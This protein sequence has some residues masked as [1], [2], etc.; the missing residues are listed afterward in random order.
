MNLST[1]IITAQKIELNFDNIETVCRICFQ[2]KRSNSLQFEHEMEMSTDNN[3]FSLEFSSIYSSTTIN[4]RTISFLD[5]MALGLSFKV[6]TCYLMV[7]R[8]QKLIISVIRGR[9]FSPN[10]LQQL[11]S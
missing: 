1:D 9:R 5:I 2:C 7:F 10:D 6:R 11:R 3:E 8:N 4:S